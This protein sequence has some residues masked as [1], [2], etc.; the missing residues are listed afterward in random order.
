MI[1]VHLHTA[2]SFFRGVPGSIAQA[3]GIMSFFPAS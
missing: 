1:E 2:F 3:L